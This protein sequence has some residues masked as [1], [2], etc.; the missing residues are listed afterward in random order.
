VEFARASYQLFG[1]S[2]GMMAQRPEFVQRPAVGPEWF[3]AWDRN[4]DGDLSFDEF[5]G[6]VQKFDELDA[7]ND[8]LID[9]REAESA[10][11]AE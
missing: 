8:D 2:D 6:S 3:R 4:G 11:A 5:L 1:P 10:G 7:D 9:H